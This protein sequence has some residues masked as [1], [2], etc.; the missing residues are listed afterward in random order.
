M[1]RR[2]VLRMGELRG[3]RIT[4]SEYP[5]DPRDF[6]AGDYAIVSRAGQRELWFRDP[7]GAVGRVI[8][9]TITEH[10]D[11]TVT[12]NPSI[13]V[14]GNPAGVFHGWLKQGVW[15]W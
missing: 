11:G 3:R 7:L 5:I 2:E 15:T 6:K 1:R 13:M 14:E 8:H 12:V 4:D 9:H 10:D